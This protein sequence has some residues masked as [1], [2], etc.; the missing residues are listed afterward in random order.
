MIKK[1]IYLK[2]LESMLSLRYNES[3]TQ[4]WLFHILRGVWYSKYQEF[5]MISNKLISIIIIMSKDEILD[6]SLIQTKY[7]SSQK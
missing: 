7:F 4:G 6:V 1:I 3:V 5:Q 2:S